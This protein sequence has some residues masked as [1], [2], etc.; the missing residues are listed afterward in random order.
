MSYS[1]FGRIPAVFPKCWFCR[2][3]LVYVEHSKNRMQKCLKSDWLA[4]VTSA[5]K[6]VHDRRTSAYFTSP[7]P[8]QLYT[9]I[10]SVWLSC[11]AAGG[12]VWIGLKCVKNCLIYYLVLSL[13]LQQLLL[14]PELMQSLP[15]ASSKYCV[16]MWVNCPADSSQASSSKNTVGPMRNFMTVC[17]QCFYCRITYH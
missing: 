14:S 16:Y 7:D 17:I 5:R 10:Q 13:L 3:I 2:I 9:T 6:L 8:T 1:V 12:A 11:V 4:S 15:Q